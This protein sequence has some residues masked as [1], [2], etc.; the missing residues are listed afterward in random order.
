MAW[1]TPKVNWDENY[2]PSP[3]DMNRIEGNTSALKSEAIEI[4]GEKTFTGDATFEQNVQVDGNATV[5]GVASASAVNTGHG[6]N[7]LYP[8]D[9]GVRTTDA[10]SHAGLTLS[11][12]FA[13]ETTPT[14]GSVTLGGAGTWTPSRGV[15]TVSV[16]GISGGGG[17]QFSVFV[18]G[19]WRTSSSL[20]VGGA[21]ITNGSDVRLVG[22]ADATIYWQKY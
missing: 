19:A 11:G 6:D 14:T 22:S 18:G 13:P 10:V 5:T 15:Y 2:E 4:S 7:E 3:E 8:M 1:T 9:Q 17:V 12:S 21:I 20:F 16:T